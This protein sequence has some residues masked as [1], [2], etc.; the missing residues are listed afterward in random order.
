M[1]LLLDARKKSQKSALSKQGNAMSGT[2]DSRNVSKNLFA[3]KSTPTGNKKNTRNLLFGLTFTAVLIGG[4]LA[5][6]SYMEAT[7]PRGGLQVMTPPPAPPENLTENVPLESASAPL[8]AENIEVASTAPAIVEIPVAQNSQQPVATEKL[9]ATPSKPR[10]PARSA[11]TV[12]LMQDP[13][14]RVD[15]ALQEAYDAYRA[16]KLTQAEQLY[17]VLYQKDSRNPDVLL[18]LAAIA[19]QHGDNNSAAQYYMRVLQLDPRNAIANSGMAA[20]STEGNSE[21]RLKS[22]LREQGNSPALNFALGNVYASQSHWSEAQQSYFT[23]AS[24]DPNNAEFSFNLAVSLDHLGQTKLAAQYYRRA[25][26]LDPSH[27]TGFNHRQIAQRIAELEP[28]P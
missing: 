15:P 4:G 18:G 25:I 1:S 5:Y 24:L 7:M 23:A 14:N 26:Q 13:E 10:A 20:I 17:R 11:N 16:G 28:M 27:G 21:S 6:L 12:H 3:A 22:L 9:M 19:Q 8:L 2:D